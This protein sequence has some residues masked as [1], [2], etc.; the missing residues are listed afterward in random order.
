VASST[1]EADPLSG[2]PD[3]LR[4]VQSCDPQQV[5]LNSRSVDVP[6][7][8]VPWGTS[9]SRGDGGA[10][11][12]PDAAGGGGLLDAGRDGGSG[13]LPCKIAVGAD[14][15]IDRNSVLALR[16]PFFSYVTW[17]GCSP[18]GSPFDHTVT[19]RDDAW[20]FQVGGGFSPLTISLTSNAILD[21]S[22]QSMRYI[23]PL[24]W[25]AVIDAQSQGLEL[26]D[27]NNPTV[28]ARTYF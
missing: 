4:C 22:P 23:Q 28:V 18:P 13:G 7:T 12:V 24:G 21:V 19:L 26:I 5:L 3:S 2:G 14:V 10:G 6:W 11:E 25:M 16:N 1:P 8:P 27:L 17:M 15:Q 9:R 20:H